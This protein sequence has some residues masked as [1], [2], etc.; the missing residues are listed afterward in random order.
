MQA[1]RLAQVIGKIKFDQMVGYAK[2]AVQTTWD[3][4]QWEAFNWIIDEE[5]GWNTKALNNASGACGLGQF[6]PCSKLHC[7]WGDGYCQIDAMV[8]YIKERYGTPSQALSFHLVTGW[9]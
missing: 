3:D 7:T 8:S 4:S 5:S 9:Y 6:L 1:D 2:V